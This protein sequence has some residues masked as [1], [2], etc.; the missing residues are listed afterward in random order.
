MARVQANPPPQYTAPAVSE[1]PEPF[2]IHTHI[3]LLYQKQGEMVQ[4]LA[5]MQAQINKLTGSGG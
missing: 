4:A 3:T 5:L 2:E 1:T